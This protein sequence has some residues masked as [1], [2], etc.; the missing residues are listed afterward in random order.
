MKSAI[1]FITMKITASCQKTYILAKKE[2]S[3]RKTITLT[4]EHDPMMI[5]GAAKLMV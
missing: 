4:L 2:Q 3:F 5:S 1:A